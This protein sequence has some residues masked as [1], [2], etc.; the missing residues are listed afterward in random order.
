[1]VNL[2]VGKGLQLSVQ[3]IKRNA[4]READDYMTSNPKWN[5]AP[6]YI[7]LGLLAVGAVFQVYRCKVCDLFV[8]LQQLIC[9]CFYI[10]SIF[11]I[12]Y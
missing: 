4:S 1:M 9:I 12:N 6:I 7:F 2:F 10:G 11:F 3:Q 8:R 5:A